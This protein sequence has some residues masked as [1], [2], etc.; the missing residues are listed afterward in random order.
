VCLLVYSHPLIVEQAL[1]VS[2]INHTQVPEFA[3][4]SE[5]YM[6]KLF[7]KAWQNLWVKDRSPT[8]LWCL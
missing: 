4:Y 1:K 2:T 8:V 6:E 7:E 3:P 5:M